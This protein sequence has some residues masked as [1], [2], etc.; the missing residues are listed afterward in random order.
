[1]P[2][3]P[4]IILVMGEAEAAFC[5]DIL[6]RQEGCPPC[7]HVPG[8]DRFSDMQATTA[9]GSRIIAFS[10]NTIVPGE[11]LTHCGHNGYNFHPG[12]PEYPGSRP[13]AFAA[14]E[15]AARFGV[16]LHHM[17]A[18]VDSGAIVDARFFPIRHI[19]HASEIATEA[20]RR[21]AMLFI[22]WA[23]ALAAIRHPLP[24]ADAMRWAGPGRREAE[25]QRLRR[26]APDT[27]A[28]EIRRR[29]RACE[30]VYCPLA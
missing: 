11:M 7:V 4:Q 19:G 10:T 16:T 28:A 27:D 22:D 3:S 14:Y 12:P 25:Y 2:A 18:R 17:R 15:D 24:V 6:R 13:S 23:P 29:M 5:A 9:P 1:M 21:L 20:Y 8:P 30:G 26:V